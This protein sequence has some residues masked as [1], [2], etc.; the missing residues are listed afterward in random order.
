MAVEKEWLNFFRDQYP[1][2][3]QIRLRELENPE[4]GFSKGQM[5]TLMEIDEDAKFHIQWK[6]GQTSCLIPGHDSFSVLPPEPVTLKLYMPLCAEVFRTDSWDGP[7]DEPEEM[8]DREI[9]R[10]EDAIVAAMVRNQCPEEAERG[11][12]RWYNRGDSVDE[13]VQS[14]VFTAEEREGKLWGVA[15]CRIVGTLSDSE[16]ETLKEYISGQASDGWGEGF[17]QREIPTRDGDMYVHLWNWENWDI[18][19]EKERFDPKLAEGLPD[20][21]FSTLASTGE[22]ICIKRG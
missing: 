9:L 16:L 10:Q 19:T 22:L 6:D 17:E 4:G 5:G 15:Q 18:L 12:M 14:V 20:L 3:S 11:I 1:V 7:S 21:C 13:K 8:T 2:G